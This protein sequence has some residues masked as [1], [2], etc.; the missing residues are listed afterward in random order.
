MI[1]RAYRGCNPNARPPTTAWPRRPRFLPPRLRHRPRCPQEGPS[2]RAQAGTSPSSLLAPPPLRSPL[3]L[4]A[5]GSP[6]AR[7]TSSA[8]ARLSG[9]PSAV[10]DS[11]VRDRP[12]FNPRVPFPAHRPAPEKGGARAGPRGAAGSYRPRGAEDPALTNAAEVAVTWP[13]RR[14]TRPPA[15]DA[16]QSAGV[17][18]PGCSPPRDW[19]LRAA[20]PRV[21]VS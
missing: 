16:A 14:A 9:H 6:R 1:A 5:P 12:P 11:P 3:S 10:R 18:P 15:N 8:V 4:G 20:P 7:G 2:D 19:L 21:P 17:P 13:R